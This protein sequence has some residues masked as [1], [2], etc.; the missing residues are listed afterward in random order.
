[1]PALARAGLDEVVTAGRTAGQD[2]LAARL[3]VR[4]DPGP[5]RPRARVE[6]GALEQL[7]DLG[8][9]RVVVPEPALDPLDLPVTLTRPFVL[10]DADGARLEAAAADTVLTDH[11]DDREPVLAAHHLLADL[12]VLYFDAPGRQRRGVVVRPPTGWAPSADFLSTVFAGLDRPG[13]SSRPSPWTTSSTPSRSSTRTARRS[14]AGS[15]RASR[16]G[17]GRRRRRGS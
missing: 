11:F 6:S 12:A 4:P 10:E 16:S 9:D 14:S 5:G 3:G 7:R 17:P 1:M 15:R 13:R 8:V 2:A